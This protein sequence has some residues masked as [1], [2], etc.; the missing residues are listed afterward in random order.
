MRSQVQ[1][2]PLPDVM[3]GGEAGRLI[4]GHHLILMAVFQGSLLL[5]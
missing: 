4:P 2:S 3:A 1:G 5:K